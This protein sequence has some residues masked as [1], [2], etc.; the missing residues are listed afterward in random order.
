MKS[1]A[2]CRPLGAAVTQTSGNICL[3]TLSCMYSFFKVGAKDERRGMRAMQ[4]S[5]CL[6]RSMKNEE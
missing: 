4:G 3:L 6:K 5:I 2:A 1:T